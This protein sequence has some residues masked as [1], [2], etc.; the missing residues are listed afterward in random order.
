MPKVIIPS[1][2]TPRRLLCK[3]PER[4]TFHWGSL[5]DDT[6]MRRKTSKYHPKVHIPY[7][8]EPG[9][10]C[11]I[12]QSGMLVSHVWGV[13]VMECGGTLM[14][15]APLTWYMQ[16][17]AGIQKV[18]PYLADMPKSK[19]VGNASENSNMFKRIIYDCRKAKTR[20]AAYR[21]QVTTKKYKTLCGHVYYLRQ[22]KI[23]TRFIEYNLWLRNVWPHKRIIHKEMAFC[24]SL[25]FKDKN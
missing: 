22:E 16:F 1:T 23:R 12:D 7:S 20:Y 4:T 21:K 8:W 11:Y 15:K 10:V 18:I 17:I 5:C 19:Y 2:N 24:K 6:N 13:Q 3:A 9:G 14:M 25:N